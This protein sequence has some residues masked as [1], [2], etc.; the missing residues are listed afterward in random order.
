MKQETPKLCNKILP[1]VVLWICTERFPG[2]LTLT[3]VR[4]DGE[5]AF[6]ERGAGINCFLPLGGC[7]VFAQITLPGRGHW[8]YQG[9]NWKS[10][11]R[12]P[13]VPSEALTWNFYL[14]IH[15]QE[16]QFPV[17]ICLLTTDD[18]SKIQFHARRSSS[19]IFGGSPSLEV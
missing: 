8:S 15:G 19:S 10:Q 6:Q 9:S 4:P 7:S 17:S 5:K 2:L 16:P 14:E 3:P 11:D 1:P 13:A 12:I 18:L